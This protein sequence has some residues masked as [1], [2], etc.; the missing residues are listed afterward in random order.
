[1]EYEKIKE[2]HRRGCPEGR[3]QLSKRGWTGCLKKVDAK[4]PENKGKYTSCL[5]EKHHKN[6]GTPVGHWGER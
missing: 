5:Y 1:M 3:E 6:R 4:D 2:D